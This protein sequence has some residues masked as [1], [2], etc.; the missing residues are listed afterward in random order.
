MHN[1][2]FSFIFADSGKKKFNHGNTPSCD[3]QGFDVEMSIEMQGPKFS[4]NRP[5][6]FDSITIL[7]RLSKYQHVAEIFFLLHPV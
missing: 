1:K 5:S 4:H 2:S 3:K 6:L 7:G